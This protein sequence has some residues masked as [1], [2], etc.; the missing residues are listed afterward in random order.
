MRVT[1]QQPL[2]QQAHSSKHAG[3]M[4]LLLFGGGPYM[5]AGPQLP[6][7]AGY[8]AGG[9]AHS[10]AQRRRGVEAHAVY[11]AAQ[12]SRISRSLC[13]LCTFGGAPGGQRADGLKSKPHRLSGTQS[14][15]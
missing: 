7:R 15:A 6:P 11:G 13:S 5:H 10:T 4:L 14:S 2:G 3:R 9:E 12:H 8:H 1:D